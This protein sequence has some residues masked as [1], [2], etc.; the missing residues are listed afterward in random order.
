MTTVGETAD[1]ARAVR[2]RC[3]EFTFLTATFVVVVVVVV[4]LFV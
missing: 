2:R 1:A 3:L 4:V